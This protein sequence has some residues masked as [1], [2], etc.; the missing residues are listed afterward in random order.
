MEI[1]PFFFL[2]RSKFTKKK[3]HSTENLR[4]TTI[5]IENDKNFACRDV[6][7]DFFCLG[8]MSE[9]EKVQNFIIDDKKQFSRQDLIIYINLVP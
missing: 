5:K 2:P 3:Y 9:A 6:D 4:V 1:E 7:G 8:C